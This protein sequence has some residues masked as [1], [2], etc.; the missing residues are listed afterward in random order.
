MFY[1][2]IIYSETADNYYTGYSED[3]WSSIIQH[4][5]NKSD[6]YTGKYDNWKLAAVFEASEE[7]GEAMKLE[8][9]IKKQKTK[10][11]IDK[12]INPD[13]VLTGELAQ[14]IR[15]PHVRDPTARA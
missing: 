11:L 15:V 10:K 13:F 9:F 8:K 14:L 7:R 1:I 4:N 6:K 3:P 12:L 2:Y 5:D